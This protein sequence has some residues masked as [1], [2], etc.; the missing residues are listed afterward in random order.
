MTFRVSSYAVGLI[1]AL[2][3]GLT[4]AARAEG[5]DC[6]SDTM[7][8]SD[9]RVTIPGADVPASAARFSGT[10]NGLWKDKDRDDGLCRTLVVE[11]V[12]PNGFARVVY[13]HGTYE[14]WKVRQ[15]NFWRASGR[16]VDG[17]LRLE[18]PYISRPDVTYRF[19]DGT[20]RETFRGQPSATLTRMS[21]VSLVGCRAQPAPA[22]PAPSRSGPR[23]RLTADEL[24]AFP[25]SGPGPAHNNYFTPVGPPRPARHAF[26]GTLQ[27]AASLLLSANQGCPGLPT[28]L[29]GLTV[30][31][32]SHGEHLVPVVRDIMRPPGTLILSPG[33]V[34]SEPGDRGMSRAA[35]PFV[36]ITELGNEAH[37]GLA[38]FLYDDTKVSALRFQVVQ[39]TAAWA[40][41]DF[42]GQATMTYAPGSIPNE[43]ALR[44]EFTVELKR[45]TPIRPWSTLAM[46]GSPVLDAFDGDAR[47]ADISANGLI[48]DGVI[49]VRGCNTRYGPYPYCRHMRHGVFSVTKSLGA[50]VALFRLAQKY[51]DQVL[52]EKI[53]DHVTVTAKHDGW[54]RVTFRDALNMATGIGELSP[55][56]EPNDVT[57]DENKPKMFK[58]GAARSAKEKL[59]ESFSY[60]R[61]AW[62]P[63]EVVRYNSTH[64]FVLAAAMD[65]FLKRREGPDAHLWDMVVKEVF[66]PIGVFHAPMAHTLEPGGGRGIPLLAFGF[67]PTIEEVA[68][69]ATLL[70]NGGRHRG[71]QLLS[72]ASLADALHRTVAA[73]LPTG[74]R[75]RFGDEQYRLSFWSVPYR[76]ASGCFFQIPYMSGLGGNLVVLLPNGVSAFRFADG[77][78]YDVDSMILAG[79]MIRPFC[80]SGPGEGSPRPP[81]PV[82]LTASELRAEL[83]GN[84]FEVGRQQIF[85]EPGGRVYGR[86]RSDA[87][88]GA[89]HVTADGRYCRT[90]N[91]WDNGRS[92]C[93]TVYRDGEAFELHLEDRLSKLVLTRRPG[94]P[95]HY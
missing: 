55:E 28:P 51:G 21:D 50:A 76:T 64:T 44:A 73:G 9:V 65:A 57:A 61:Y 33:R 20:L 29:P 59:D 24:L 68:K 75:N 95:E 5:K 89:W 63:G 91:V 72:A 11:E 93:Y 49:Y 8:P 25:S 92:R 69:I 62:G 42:W 34:W 60:G 79:E 83:P 36:F 71:E 4:A 58:W 52:D 18:V 39:E 56:R 38:T 35:F 40:K 13:S 78:N 84:T 53:K 81:Q 26:K 66:R 7:L 16:V 86:I 88:V 77:D 67:Y 80:A 14:G 37:N 15:P 74:R 47:P 2:I 12:L 70:Q 90:W 94:N 32:F 10:W 31:F 87:D 19:V 30:A 45:E 22:P 17:V 48:V 27:I 54:E 3:V 6:Q 41:F 85:I 1:V 43:R 46:S 82:P 23:D